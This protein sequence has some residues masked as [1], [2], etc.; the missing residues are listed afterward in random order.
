MEWI[1]ECGVKGRSRLFYLIHRHRPA[2]LSHFPNRDVT[3][4]LEALG[5][6]AQRFHLRYERIMEPDGDGGY[7]EWLPVPP[8]ADYR[9]ANIRAGLPDPGHVWD[10]G[11]EAGLVL[12]LDAV[13][14]P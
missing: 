2:P 4:H 6:P 9:T 10:D 5:H 13:V 8:I 7:A 12:D 1:C 14:W 3:R 11:E